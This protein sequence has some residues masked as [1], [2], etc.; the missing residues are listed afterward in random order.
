[1]EAV[2]PTVVSIDPSTSKH[3]E[4]KAIKTS[5]HTDSTD[6][7]VGRDADVGVPGTAEAGAGAR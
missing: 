7:E 1:M 4:V 5:R 6:A 2:G 3:N